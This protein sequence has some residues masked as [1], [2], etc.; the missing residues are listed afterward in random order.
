MR[1]ELHL[2]ELVDRYLDGSM[3]VEERAV[4]ET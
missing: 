1:D 4:F 3:R 2:M